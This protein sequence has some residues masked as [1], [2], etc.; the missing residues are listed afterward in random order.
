[1]WIEKI[2]PWKVIYLIWWCFNYYLPTSS[3]SFIWVFA[4]Q[5]WNCFSWFW[6][7]P[8]FLFQWRKQPQKGQKQQRNEQQQRDLQAL[9]GVSTATLMMTT[10]GTLMRV[11]LA[12]GRPAPAQTTASSRPWPTQRMARNIALMSALKHFGSVLKMEVNMYI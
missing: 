8:F 5:S 1:M 11:P 9:W 10:A 3:V 6:L 4:I 7:L 12:P 2:T